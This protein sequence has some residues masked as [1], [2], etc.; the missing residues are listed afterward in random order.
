MQLA[1]QIQ[2]I[3]A[4]VMV[5]ESHRADLGGADTWMS[6]P[7]VLALGMVCFIFVPGRFRRESSREFLIAYRPY[8]GFLLDITCTVVHIKGCIYN[9][10]ALSFMFVVS[11]KPCLT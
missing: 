6:V 7:T 8:I 1:I 3:S 9:A 10:F 4:R 5:Y 2:S 11:K